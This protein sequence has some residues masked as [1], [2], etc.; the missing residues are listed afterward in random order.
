MANIVRSSDLWDPFRLVREALRW[1]PARELEGYG[2]VEQAL[3]ARAFTPRFDVKETKGAYVFR[4]D[5]P[6]VK[7]ADV[8]ISLTG[9]RL[10]IAGKREQE[11][12]DEGDRYFAEESLYGRFNLAFTVPS[13][14]DPEG[15]TASLDNG[16]L[17]VTVAKRPEVQARR[18]PIGK[19]A[20]EPKARA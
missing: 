9:N 15:V 8:E 7:E 2:S 19:G 12:R 5:V 17:T 4:L 13:G 1:D 11:R 6:G 16:V 18:I 3:P 10:T 14:S 20:G